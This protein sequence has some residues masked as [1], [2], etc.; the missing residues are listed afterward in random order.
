M[1]PRAKETCAKG[2]ATAPHGIVPV[3]RTAS[4]FLY[5]ASRPFPRPWREGRSVPAHTGAMGRATAG[6][7]RPN[8]SSNDLQRVGPSRVKT[9]L[10]PTTVFSTCMSLILSGGTLMGLPERTTKSASFPLSMDPLR[11]SSKLQAAA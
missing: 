11:S 2:P 1:V 10:P 6:T 8:P 4:T 5:W 7:Y 3:V 9:V